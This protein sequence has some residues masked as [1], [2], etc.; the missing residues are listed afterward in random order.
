[1]LSVHANLNRDTKGIFNE[2]AFTRMKKTAIFINTARGGLHV[3]QDLI[4]ALE[5]NEIWGAGLDVT[6]PEPMHPDNVLLSMPRVIV[7]PHIGSSTYFTR[8][9]MAR[10]AAENIIHFF[11]SG[12]LLHQV[13]M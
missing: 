2:R 7:L 11:R 13:S 10:L 3:E 4:E 1:V 8:N 6:N 5:T 9:E 12:E